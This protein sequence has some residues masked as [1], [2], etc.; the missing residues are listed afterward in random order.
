[1]LA[2]FF[3]ERFTL[4]QEHLT[5][6]GK[7]EVRIERRTAPNAPRLNATVFGRRELD[8]IKGSTLLEQQGNIAFQRGLIAFD[9][10]VIVRLLCDQIGGQH[11][12]GQQ[13]IAGTGR[14]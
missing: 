4:D 12:L 10:E 13:R 6:A 2:G 3:L 11:A 9:G 1:M 7:V 5:D 14:G 8:E